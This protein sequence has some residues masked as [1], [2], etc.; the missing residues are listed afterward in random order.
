MINIK[1]FLQLNFDKI[2]QVDGVIWKKKTKTRDFLIYYLSNFDLYQ[3]GNRKKYEV[4][5]IFNLDLG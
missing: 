4:N 5:K 1:E 2:L 3:L